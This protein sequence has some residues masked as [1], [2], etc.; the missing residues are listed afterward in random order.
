MANQGYVAAL[1]DVGSTTPTAY[2]DGT[3][4]TDDVNASR[5]F[6]NRSDAKLSTA[7]IL[8]VYDNQ[9]VIYIPARQ[10]IVLGAA[11]TLIDNA[12]AGGDTNQA[13]VQGGGR[14]NLQSA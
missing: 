12:P 10:T 4:F 2:W 3:A 8:S 1:V 7:Q 5:I 11:G 9:D 13:T 14:T 6:P